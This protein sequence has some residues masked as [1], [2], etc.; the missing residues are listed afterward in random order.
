LL[1]I[2]KRTAALE[3][4]LI[5]QALQQTKGNRSQAAR[6]LDISYKALVYK[7]RGYGLGD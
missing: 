1:S 4:S 2:K 5:Q 3:Q 7:I 6:L